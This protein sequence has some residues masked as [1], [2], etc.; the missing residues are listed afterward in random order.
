MNERHSGL[1]HE[2]CRI[3]LSKN[4]ERM[5]R[6]FLS[7]CKEQIVPKG[8]PPPSPLTSLRPI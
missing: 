6:T 5:S 1:D 3:S 2:H 4:P 8:N 7:L